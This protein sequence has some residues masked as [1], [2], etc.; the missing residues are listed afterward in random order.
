MSLTEEE[1]A[2]TLALK[3]ARIAARDAHHVYLATCY[4]GTPR[5]MSDAATAM[6]VASA[7]AIRAERELSKIFC[8]TVSG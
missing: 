4:A 1:L 3:V 2:A 7:L 8:T 6:D 5:G